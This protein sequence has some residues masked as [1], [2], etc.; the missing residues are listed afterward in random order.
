MK[1]RQVLALDMRRNG[2]DC[3]HYA[4]GEME[5]YTDGFACIAI[6]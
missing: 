5:A 4:R 6:F 2:M 1:V 3:G